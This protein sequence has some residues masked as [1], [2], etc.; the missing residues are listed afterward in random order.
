[1]ASKYRIQIIGPRS[2]TERIQKG[3]LFRPLFLNSFDI[4]WV[5]DSMRESLLNCSEMSPGVAD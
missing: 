3:E 2:K 4:L 5:T 1:M